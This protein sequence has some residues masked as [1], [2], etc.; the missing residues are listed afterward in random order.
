MMSK[1]SQVLHRRPALNLTAHARWAHLGAVGQP[2]RLVHRLT[3]DV[4]RHKIYLHQ[5][6]MSCAL[7]ERTP[8]YRFEH[9]PAYA[10]AFSVLAEPV[11]QPWRTSSQYAPLRGKRARKLYDSACVFSATLHDK[12]LWATSCCL[13]RW[14]DRTW[15]NRDIWRSLWTCRWKQR[16]GGNR[17]GPQSWVLPVL[18]Q[19]Y[20]RYPKPKKHYEKW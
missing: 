2:C 4:R 16:Y 15:R 1:V 20:H 8:H 14:P 19:K 10:T 11:R 12:R 9:R 18:F 6:T 17:I 3:N 7:S 13:K 5:P